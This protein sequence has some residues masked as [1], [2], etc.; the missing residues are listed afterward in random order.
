M[1]FL[2]MPSLYPPFWKDIGEKTEPIFSEVLY[3]DELK[4]FVSFPS[5]LFLQSKV[6][7]PQRKNDVQ[8]AS[9]LEIPSNEVDRSRVDCFG[10]A[11]CCNLGGREQRHG[12]VYD[13]DAGENAWNLE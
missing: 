13:F 7:S 3:C 2:T 9:V 1:N 8:T 6:S 11:R 10:H 4:D 12:R 5:R